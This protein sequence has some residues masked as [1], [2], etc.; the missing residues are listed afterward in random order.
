[1][2]LFLD[3]D[4]F[5]ETQKGLAELIENE[6]QQ[7]QSNQ[8]SKVLENSTQRCRLPPPGFSHMTHMNA[9]G[10]GVPRAATQTSKILPFMN[11]GGNTSQS[12]QSHNWPHHS[13]QPQQSLNYGIHDQMSSLISKQGLGA[14]KNSKKTF[15]RKLNSSIFKQFIMYFIPIGFNNVSDWGLM[16]PAIVSFRPY[17]SFMSGPP[18]SQQSQND[19][20][21]S[22]PPHIAQQ[23]INGQFDNSKIKSSEFPNRNNLLQSSYGTPHGLLQN[24][25]I[26][27]Q[28]Q[29]NISQQVSFFDRILETCETH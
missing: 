13:G 3:F 8:P 2:F 18:Q 5:F 16:D 15:S 21:I 17:Q 24:G 22:P 25:I 26:G 1:M 11:S 6:Q 4:P 19:M 14:N 10:L 27:Q 23:Q 29:Q 28:Q 7:T 12:Q 9:F 20:F